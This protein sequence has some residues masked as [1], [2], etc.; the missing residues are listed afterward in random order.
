MTTNEVIALLITPL[1]GL[2]VGAA[3]YW[4]AT[5]GDR[6]KRHPAE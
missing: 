5:R 2:I 1:G 6:A 4:I 3:A